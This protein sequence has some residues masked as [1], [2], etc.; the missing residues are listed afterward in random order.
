MFRK[1]IALILIFVMLVP[2]SSAV[3]ADELSTSI[4]T[5]EQDIVIIH[6][7]EKNDRIEALLAL[8]GKLELDYE[9]NT[10]AIAFIDVQLQQL[11][12]EN[13]SNAE[14]MS[15]LGMVAPA[16]EIPS[17]DYVR[18]TSRRLVVTYHGQHFELQIYEAFACHNE[19][20]LLD[21]TAHVETEPK[22]VR[23]AVDTALRICAAHAMQGIVDL[24]A[25]AEQEFLGTSY[26][27]MA[28][29]SYD[30]T[31][32]LMEAMSTSETI[33]NVEG[34]AQAAISTR[35]RYIFVKPYQTPDEGNQ[36]LSYIG[37]T[38]T[39]EIGTMTTVWEFTEDDAIPHIFHTNLTGS[40]SSPYYDDFSEAAKNHFNYRY[41]GITTFYD[42]YYLDEITFEFFGTEYVHE[43][44][45]V[46]IDSDLM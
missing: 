10:D 41:G 1:M 22:T 30:I 11:G 4:Q 34:T 19:S 21:S 28:Q 29:L 14:I 38:V 32:A 5:E 43:I 33:E 44:N 45:N 37:N 35:M 27:E 23:V 18:W 3:A 9:A 40:L 36:V 6:D 46:W 13:V 20:P 39:Y 24:A 8:R 17:T 26:I 12:I 2:L 7:P 16:I 42:R 15:K 25:E 31:T